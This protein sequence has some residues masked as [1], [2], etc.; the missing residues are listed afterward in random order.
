[1][2]AANSTST[3]PRSKPAKPYPDFP[4]FPHS[5]GQWYKEVRGRFVYFG[6]WDNP[7]AALPCQISWCPVSCR[8]CAVI[9]LYFNVLILMFLNQHG[10]PW[11][12]NPM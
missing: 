3:T 1:M 5:S 11:S 12:C 9:V 10:A 7:V 8:R 4:L 2:T 6:R